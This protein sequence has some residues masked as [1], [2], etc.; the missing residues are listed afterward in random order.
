[1]IN[2]SVIDNCY[3]SGNVSAA[4]DFVGGLVGI[5]YQ[6]STIS[7]CYSKTNVNGQEDFIGG[8]VSY[9][10]NSLIDNCYSIGEVSGTSDYIGGLMGDK[11]AYTDITDSYYDSE[12]S[13]QSDTGKGVPKS[14]AEMK[15][16]ST[17]EGWDFDTIWDIDGV[18]N[19]GYP[20]LRG[21]KQSDGYNLTITVE[22]NGTTS[23]QAGTSQHE[24]GKN[25]L[26]VA[27]PEPGNKLLRWEG[28]GVEDTESEYTQIKMT[29]NRSVKAVFAEEAI[30]KL[31]AAGGGTTNPPPGEISYAKGQVVTLKASPHSGFKF[32]E[33]TKDIS[34]TNDVY[35]LL[36]DSD[37]TV[38]AIFDDDEDDKSTKRKLYFAT[39]REK[40]FWMVNGKWRFFATP[41]HSNLKKLEADDHKQYLNN[42]RH[43]KI[44]RHRLGDT[45]PHDS[46]E[47]LNNVGFYSHKKI[48]EHIE[49]ME[50]PHLVTAT[51]VG[52]IPY[53]YGD[54]LPEAGEEYRGFFF[55]VPG[56][57]GPPEVEDKLYY[58]RSV[59]GGTTYEWKEIIFV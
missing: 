1:M 48:D 33:W 6:Y 43:D 16:K 18:T 3:S 38:W 13:G 11:Y 32:K 50:N 41:V 26:L 29:A 40:A 45:V 9:C 10:Y 19:D 44:S 5:N 46:H 28:Y 7:N 36:M 2:H 8:L 30:L 59:D 55:T 49:S 24:A 14:T 47:N 39:A 52:A 57:V 15:Q 17:Y 34:S 42:E 56:E 22:G 58:C 12:T 25:V 31:V 21:Q 54:T 23:P 4:S 51:Q 35:E 27:Y 53:L 37:K 20:F